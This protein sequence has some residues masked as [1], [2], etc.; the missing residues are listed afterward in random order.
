M[1]TD[2]HDDGKKDGDM[3]MVEKTVRDF[4][5]LGS[6]AG[7]GIPSF[8]CDCSE[9]REARHNPKISRTRSGALIRDGRY[10]ILI[11]ASPDLRQQ[12]ICQNITCFDEVWLTHWHYDH[13]GGLGELEYYVRLNRKK[14]ILF[15]LPPSAV[16]SFQAAFPQLSD[17][18][19]IRPWKFGETAVIKQLQIT[20]L[21]AEHGIETAGILVESPNV[22]LAYF[23]D[24]AGLPSTSEERVRNADWLICDSTFYGDN[25]YPRAHM[26][27]HQAIALGEK[28]AAKHTVLTHLSIHYAQ[29]VT[30]R[31][32]K[33]KLA[34]YPAVDIAYDGMNVKL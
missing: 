11:D 31:E 19:E 32:L 3:T 6:G 27:V 18:M 9:C 16:E 1:P 7:P 20:P 5:I 28:I 25:W 22:K 26:S 10:Q 17:V 8:F 24:T 12:L 29:A 34:L 14:S 4:T 23:T 15:R 13:F 30:T 33:E 21:P 2:A